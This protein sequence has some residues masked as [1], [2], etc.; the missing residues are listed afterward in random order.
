MCAQEVAP[1]PILRRHNDLCVRPIAF[2]LLVTLMHGSRAGATIWL[3]RKRMQ[4]AD[5]VPHAQ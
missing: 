1:A 4:L 5:G 2:D 3:C